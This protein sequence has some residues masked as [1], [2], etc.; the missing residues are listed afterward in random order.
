MNAT[1]Q[2]ICV[3]SGSADGLAPKYLAAA[4]TLG[5]LLAEK[6]IQAV[7][8]GGKTG[9]M[10]AFA[11]GVLKRGGRITGVVPAVLNSP[12]L[13]HSG[14]SELILT[15]NMHE[16]KAKMASLADAFIAL[17][18]GYGT[19]EELFETL[20]WAQIGLHSKPIGL[21]NTGGY[22]DPLLRM[23]EHITREGF[24]LSE[25]PALLLA[26]PSPEDLLNQLLAYAPPN[27]SNRWV[28]REGK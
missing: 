6:G 4:Q 9:L 20:T 26:S 18:G 15:A 24:I 17:P 21:L 7:F 22:Y 13:I 27:G 11:E 3:Y 2:S 10:G 25:H 28:E 19:L 8:G 14:L 16:R 12:A 23:I 5:G 1:I